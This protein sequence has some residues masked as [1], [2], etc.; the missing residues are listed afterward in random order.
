VFGVKLTDPL[1][2]VLGLYAYLLPLALYAAWVSLAMWDLA[3]RDE[4]TG[5][6]RVGLAAFVLGV[7]LVGP[8]GYLAVGAKTVPR[9]LRLFLAFGGL[10]LYLLLAAVSFALGRA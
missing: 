10:G 3:R 1:A 2:L 8:V 5:P 7:P 6:V 4:L 9:G